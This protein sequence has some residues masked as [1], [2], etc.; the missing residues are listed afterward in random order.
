MKEI[1]KIMTKNLKRMDILELLKDPLFI[2]AKN[3]QIVS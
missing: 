2:F 1:K 3:K